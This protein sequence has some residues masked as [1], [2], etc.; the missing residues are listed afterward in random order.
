MAIE[1]E[2]I[3]LEVIEEEEDHSLEESV[4]GS[5]EVVESSWAVEGK[6]SSW[7]VGVKEVMGFSVVEVKEV[8]DSSVVGSVAVKISVALAVSSL[9]EFGAVAKAMMEV[10]CSSEAEQEV[11]D[12]WVEESEVVESSSEE[13]QA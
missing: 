3:A 2:V 4:V 7:V 9:E 10:D 13:S 12:S 11:M 1:V 6:V 5:E 8:K